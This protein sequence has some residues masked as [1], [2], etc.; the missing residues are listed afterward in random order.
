MR[1]LPVLILMGLAAPA[2]AQ[3]PPPNRQESRAWV[4]AQFARSDLNR[5]GVLSR[6][7][8]T[9][10]VN[11]HYGRLSTG[12]SRIMTNMWFNRLDGNRSNSISRSEALGA[13][14]EFWGRFDRNRD[15]RI[16]PRE[17]PAAE[18]FLRNPA[19]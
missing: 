9:Q 8:V 6:G 16:G 13:A 1:F 12:R 10:A 14:D 4:R 3:S 15:G 5:D 19:R 17:R 18:A 7:E 11:R 2:I